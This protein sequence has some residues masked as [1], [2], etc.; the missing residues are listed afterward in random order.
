[1]KVIDG[2][3]IQILQSESDSCF[4]FKNC[5]SLLQLNTR[6]PLMAVNPVTIEADPFLFVYKDRL[7]LFY[8]SKCLND[9]GIIKMCWTDDGEFWSEPVV[10]L[11]E[12]F[13]LSYPYIFQEGDDVYMLPE[14]SQANRVCLYKCVNDS[15]TEFEFHSTL[16]EKEPS[17]TITIN[18]SDSSILK[19]K[20]IYYLFST[21]QYNDIYTLELY[22]SKN[23]D[24][25][26][27]AHP[28]SP[29]CVSNEFGRNAGSIFMYGK[30]IF[31]VSQ[32][33]SKEYGQN[34]SVHN[35]I[36]LSANEYKESLYMRNI[37]SCMFSSFYCYGGHQFN[38]VF[39]K[40]KII[41]AT[42]AKEHY[43]LLTA[44]IYA[45]L[46]SILFH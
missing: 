42:D 36:K 11:Q 2:F 23:F 7:F 31:R 35:I 28:S 5:K 32:D 12:R 46:K 1:M 27:K 39:W 24:S 43:L 33:C 19:Y 15:L 44:R 22:T 6:I 10:V 25:G 18:Y 38:V 40:N 26:Y 29:I 8:E 9:P 34:V 20:D 30:E 41:I 13:H 16:L 14:T 21:I 37:Y 3:K 4:D 17:R 45:K